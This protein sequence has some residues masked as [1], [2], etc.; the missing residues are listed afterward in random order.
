ML[1]TPPP[2]ATLAYLDPVSWLVTLQLLAGGGGWL[3]FRMRKMLRFFGFRVLVASAEAQLT[4]QSLES[5]LLLLTAAQSQQRLVIVVEGLRDLPFLQDVI[6]RL[7]GP[8]REIWLLSAEALPISGLSALGVELSYV[9]G[10]KGAAWQ[11]LLGCLA[12]SIVLTTLTD[13]GTPRFPKS[14]RARYAYVFHSLVSTHV[15]Y[16]NG[17]FDAYDIV[18][19]PGVRHLEELRRRDEQR[20]A[21]KRRLLAAGY[22]FSDRLLAFQT[23]PAPSGS[24]TVLIGP[25]WGN[26]SAYRKI[27]PAIV[28]QAVSL[29]WNVVVRPH[30]ETI[31]RS[32]K[33]MREFMRRFAGDPAVTFDGTATGGLPAREA[34]VL[35][36]D[37]S[38]IALEFSLGSRTTIVFVDLPMKVRNAGW[39]TIA[40]SSV[41]LDSRSVIGI[42]LSHDEIQKLGEYIGRPGDEIARRAR[43]TPEWLSNAGSAAQVIARELVDELEVPV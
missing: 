9:D 16:E 10:L 13:L 4:R 2:F 31:K 34:E 32:A 41:E 14:S 26:D 12:A 42:P 15:A 39:R 38:G 30:P 22:P 21:P 27:W 19:C 28:D 6:A 5:A 7:T 40:P 8:G 20:H 24:G 29:G 17:S 37:W 36:T 43:H 18:F 11:K 3:A 25:S 23:K 1:A 33:L 35:I